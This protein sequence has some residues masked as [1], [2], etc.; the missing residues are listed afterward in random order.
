MEIFRPYYGFSIANSLIN[1]KK[2]NKIIKIYEI[3]CGKGTLGDSILEY[4][5]KFE[6]NMYQNIEY[7]FVDISEVI[8]NDCK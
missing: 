8:L 7:N 6:K 5:K 1:Q 3:G 4:F 2:K